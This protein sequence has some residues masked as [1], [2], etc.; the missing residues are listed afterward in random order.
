MNV[1]PVAAVPE[2]GSVGG[3]WHRA[4]IPVAGLLA[5]GFFVG[6]ALPYLMLDQGV[7]ARYGS[8]R[9]WLLVHIAG[10]AIALLAGP[11]QLWLG[12]TNRAM[13]AH[14]RLGL[15]YVSSV[16][17]SS[18]AAFYLATHTTL[19]WVFGAGL[20]ALGVAWLVTT[21]LAVVAIRRGLIEQHREWMIRSYVVTFAFVT[22]RMLFGALQMAAIGTRQEQLAAASWF[23]WAVPLL[24]TEAVLQGRK[25]LDKRR[26]NAATLALALFAAIP[27]LVHGQARLTGADLDGL[28]RDQSG[29]ALPDALVTVVNTETN[30]ARTI[31]TDA[32]GQFR[33]LA[34]P[35]GSYRV[36]I[37]Y[38]GFAA[39]TRD[40]IV[41]LLGQAMSFDFTMTLAVAEQKVTVLAATPVIDVGHTSI[42]SVVRHEQ[43]DSLPI[44]G[45][46]FMSFTVITPGVTTDRTPQQGATSTSGLSFTGQRG[47]SNNVMVDGLDNNDHTVGAVRATFSQEAIR[48]FQVLT[49]SYSAEFGKAAGGVVNIVTKSGTNDFRGTAFMYYRDDAMNARDHFERFDPFGDPV[50]RTKAPFRQSQWGGILGGPVRKS[51]TFFFGSFER[52]AIDAH[53]FVNIDPH[54]ADVLGANGFAV[55]LGHVPY[56][57]RTTE[58][59]GKIDHHLSPT[60]TLVIRANVSDTRNENIEPFGGLVARSRGAELLRDDL[61]VSASHTQVLG[62]WLNEARGQFARQDFTVRSLDPA[63]NGPCLTDADGGPTLELP[64]VASVGRQRFTP[65]GRENDRYQFMETLSLV[66]GAHSVKTGVEANV[67]QN[68]L[69]SLPLH[70]GGRFIFAA[71]PATPALGLSQPISAVDALERGLPAAYIQ[72]YGDPATSFASSDLSFFLQDELRLGRK[73]VIKPGIR[74]QKQFWPGVSFNVSSVGGE[75]LE[76]RLAQSG[77]LAPR[78]AA[79]Y[80]P[81]GDGRTSI[82]AAYGRYDDYQILASVVTGQ[83]VNGSTGVRTLALRLPSSIAAWQTPGHRLPEPSTP[84][85]SVEVSTTPDMKV[86]YAEHTAVGIDRELAR[87]MSL[88]VNAVRIRGGNQ[89]GTIDYNPLVPALGP[90]RR[91]NDVDGRIGTSA[92][93]LQYTSFGDSW[94]QGVTFAL[95]KRF[96]ADHQLLASYTVSK[97][98]DTSTDFQSAFLPED[99]GFGRDPTDPTGL[100]RGFDPARERGPATHDQRHR[101]VVSGLYQFPLGLQVSSIVT[102]ASGRPFTPL[103]GADLNGDGDGGAFPPDRARR[104]PADPDTSIGRN[105]ASMPS[106]VTIDVRATKRVPIQG[107]AAMDV[108]VEAFNLFNRSNFSEVNAIFG[109]GAFPDDPQRDGQ[110]RVTYGLFEQALPPRQVQLALRLSF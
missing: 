95:K 65:Q 30:V 47:R 42:S 49:N 18:V 89:L 64:G 57:V 94:Y 54:A 10:G 5:L 24:V 99:N 83:I 4:T 82:H 34:L 7:L 74:Y 53:N 45:R 66:T 90:G 100:P 8:R 21:T 35:P 11:V 38:P 55:E 86:P 36:T 88:S 1:T 9:P 26:F 29:G 80:D 31:A 51:R 59:L 40:G 98:E 14:R 106:Q 75:R 41:L 78:L 37:D 2:S 79:A 28:V 44:N 77:H 61:S 96:S 69:A 102:A 46:N 93:V 16:G 63:C 58:A 105:S 12:I 72:G 3:W 68:S 85:P 23:C 91:P 13:S 92:S 33:A 56:A 52:L 62:R 6:F 97:A 19:G 70:F 81:V 103:A 101:L 109:R 104:D 22:F 50:E 17:I 107:R 76:Y 43:I 71:L 60:S 84:F 20:T 25:I 27:T 67:L 48:E 15:T 108:L 110:G 87:D 32:T 39:H 73:L